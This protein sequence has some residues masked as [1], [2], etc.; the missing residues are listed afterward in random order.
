MVYWPGINANIEE[1]AGKCEICL[2]NRSKQQKEPMKIHPLP[3]LPW[4]KVGTDLFEFQG[5]HYFLMVDNYS[6]FIEVTPLQRDTRSTTVIKAIKTNIARYGIMETLV[7]D[8]GP[9][10]ISADFQQFTSKYGIKHV[11]SSLTH[12]QSNGLAEESVRQIKDLMMKCQQSQDDFYLALLDLRNTPRDDLLGSPMQRLQGR[13]GQT[14][15]PITD[16]KLRPSIIDPAAIHD[17]MMHY[18]RQQK[19]Y[20][21]RNAKP[22]QPLQSNQ[23]V[24]VWTPNG[25]K[26]AT[27]IKSHE[28]PNSHI[29]KAGQQG[30]T[31]RRN[32]K[33][34]MATGEKPHCI[35]TAAPQLPPVAIINRPPSEPLVNQRVLIPPV[36]PQRPPILQGTLC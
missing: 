10:F 29:I 20:Y 23:A 22:L 8:N 25:W 27:Y 9:Q 14:R 24:R 30:K 2:E 3:T 19:L 15:L 21:D 1:I 11:T 28:A 26:P 36:T 17:R 31:Y 13:R 6:N 35:T 4:N 34:L 33:H 18:R 12:Q 32:R 5:A 16:S 7:S